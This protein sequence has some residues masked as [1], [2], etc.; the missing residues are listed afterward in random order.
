MKDGDE[1]IVVDN[2]FIG[3]EIEKLLSREFVCYGYKK[4][5]RYLNRL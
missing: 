4:T 1:T 2:S 5:A 3:N